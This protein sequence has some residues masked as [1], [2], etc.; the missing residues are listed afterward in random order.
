MFVRC[1]LPVALF[2]CFAIGTLFIGIFSSYIIDTSNIKVLVDSPYC[3][4]RNAT[5]WFIGETPSK[6]QLYVASY[7]ALGDSYMTDCYK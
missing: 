6:Q 1:L 5:A 7:E 2:F 3:G 4:F